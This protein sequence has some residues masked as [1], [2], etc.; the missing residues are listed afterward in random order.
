MEYGNYDTFISLINSCFNILKSYM[1]LLQHEMMKST[2]QP[3]RK[4]EQVY[5]KT[6]LS[7]DLVVQALEVT[8]NGEFDL[9]INRWAWRRGEYNQ[10]K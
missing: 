9:L 7:Y 5:A 10:S 3:K 4:L 2:V 1:L 6:S 8:N